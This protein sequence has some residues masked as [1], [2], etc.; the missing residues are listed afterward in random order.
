MQSSPHIMA[1][2]RARSRG[3]TLVEIIITITIIG[4]VTAA[5]AVGVMK[6]QKNANIGVARTACDNIRTQTMAWKAIHPGED[7]PTVDA[8]K[9]SGDL[10]KGFNIK[11]PWNV[12]YRLSCEADEITCTS[13]GPDKKEGTDDDIVRPPPDNSPGR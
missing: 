5:I 8:L 9:A 11:D 1:L 6:A 4:M 3:L 2:R 7:C 10:D 13:N 12:P